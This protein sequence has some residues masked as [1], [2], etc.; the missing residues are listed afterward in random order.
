MVVD[1]NK[2]KSELY[3]VGIS[4][5]SIYDLVNSSKSY[6]QGI[7]ILIKFLKMGIS[8]D[9]LKEGVIRSLAVKEAKGFAGSVLIEEF[10]RTPKN[11]IVLRWVIG[12]AIEVVITSNEIASVIEI[13]K[14]KTNGLSRQMFILALGKLPSKETEQV[15]L[16]LLDDEEVVLYAITALTKIKSKRGI[17]KIKKYLTHSNPLIRK[18][19]QKA[20]KKRN[21]IC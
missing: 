10:N 15:L 5:D 18:E 14:D 1:E 21:Q 2:I 9:T 4:I 11:K 13:V 7:P 20:L 12:S 17:R 3:R 6:P 16:E 8:D 19:A